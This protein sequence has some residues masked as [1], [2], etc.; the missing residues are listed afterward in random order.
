[1]TSY[2]IVKS[3]NYIYLIQGGRTT[4]NFIP[5]TMMIK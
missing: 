5:A 1:M 4:V 3:K 2:I